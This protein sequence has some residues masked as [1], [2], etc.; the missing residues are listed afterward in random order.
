MKI[1]VSKKELYDKLK[2]VTKVVT[3][4]KTLPILENYMFVVENRILT[5]TGSDGNGEIVARVNL[6]DIDSD[7]QIKFVVDRTLFTAL[8]ELPDQPIEL[9][10]NSNYHIKVI[11]HNGQFELQGADADAFPCMTMPDEFQTIEMDRQKLMEGIKTV[12]PFVA[13][14]DLR[15]VMNGVYLDSKAN[16]LTFVS[17]DAHVLACREYEQD[18][19]DFNANIPAKAAKIILSILSEYTE[20]NVKVI[21]SFKNI[22][23]ETEKY[24]VTYRLIEGRYPNYRNVIPNGQNLVVTLDKYEFL[25]L[26]K[27]ISVFSNVSSKLLKLDIGQGVI[28]VFAQDVD[29]SISANETLMAEIDGEDMVIGFNATRL[30]DVI[31]AVETEQCKLN[32]LNPTRAGIINPVGVDGVTLLIMPMTINS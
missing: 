10:I 4:S 21:S 32:L 28:K 19:P 17:T 1:T 14:D 24:T 3:T 29:Y 26:I 30:A 16:A 23:V 25:S 22:S 5:I 11:Y 8:A 12:L 6:V 13:N 15:P 20:E 9:V 7:Q 27:R 2:M 31:A 18:L